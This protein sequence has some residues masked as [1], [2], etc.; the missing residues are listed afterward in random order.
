MIYHFKIHRE[1]KGYRAQGIEIPGCYTQG[2]S[3]KELEINMV[4]A[5]NLAVS[6]PVKSTDFVPLPDTKIEPSRSIAEVALD[7]K[8]AFSYWVRR[9]RNAH[10][11]SQETTASK[12]GFKSVYQYQRL[13]SSKYNPTLNTLTLVKSVFPELSLD[14]LIEG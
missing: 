4:E 13:E 2:D 11:W 6:E 1:G 10:R 14:A 7:P 12:M 8:I 3:K 9:C 5:L